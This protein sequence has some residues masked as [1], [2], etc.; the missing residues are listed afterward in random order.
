M[1]CSNCQAV[2]HSAQSCSRKSLHSG[3]MHIVV[4]MHISIMPDMRGAPRDC[5]RVQPNEACM[6]RQISRLSN[7]LSPFA[8]LSKP[9]HA[10][11]PPAA[12]TPRP[13]ASTLDCMSPRLLFY[14][15]AKATEHP[16]PNES[17]SPSFAPDYPVS[18]TACPQLQLQPVCLAEM[19][20]PTRY[21]LTAGR[22]IL[23]C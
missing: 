19:S 22:R 17:S 8:S 9:T 3:E 2:E 18:R 15:T 20:K 14:Y 23:T 7:C 10:Q 16:P 12:Q 13:S 21:P 6:I 11:L 5:I 1:S 4:R